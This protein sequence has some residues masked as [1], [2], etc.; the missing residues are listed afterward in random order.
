MSARHRLQYTS[1]WFDEL[2]SNI[3]ITGNGMIKD[4]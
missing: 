3:E 1:G 2:I 4:V